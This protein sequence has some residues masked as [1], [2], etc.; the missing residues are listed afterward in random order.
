MVFGFKIEGFLMRALLCSKFGPPENLK[1]VEI[2]DLTPGKGQVRIAI[3]ACGVNFPDTL[4]I[5]D[6][7]QYKPSL[8]FSPGGEVCGTID[9]LGEDVTEYKVGDRV[10]A[11]TLFGG[12]AE[13][14]IVESSAL[15]RQPKTMDGVVAAGFTMTYG[16]SMHALTQRAELRA[17]ETLLVLGAGGGVGL[18]AVE[19]G[20]AM[21]AT[22]IAAA[23]SPKKLDAAKKA[24]ADYLI[25]YSKENLRDQIMQIVGKKGVD[26]VYD[27]VGGELFELALRST[28]WNGRV[29]VVGF[30]S[31]NIPK[32]SINLALLKGCSIVGVFWGAFRLKE[33][34]SDNQNFVQLF[35]WFKE[36]KINPYISH[37]YALEE[38]PLAIQKLSQRQAVGKIVIKI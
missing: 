14:I 21:G 35:S 6:K 27:P 32:V 15:L 37:A 8:P 30:A 2:P 36:G 19:I 34:V 25:N 17:G 7:Y 3:E 26:V 33:T 29:L 24:G 4:I 10:M 38:A 11:M 22:V 20:K 12:F 23:S 1:I 9:A 5:R 18:A 31:G 16:T 13:Q 28:S